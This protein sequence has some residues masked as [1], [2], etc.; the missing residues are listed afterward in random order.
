MLYIAYLLHAGYYARYFHLG[1][2]GESHQSHCEAVC[3]KENGPGAGGW[4]SGSKA[5]RL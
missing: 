4:S 1:C 5:V 2:L 3:W